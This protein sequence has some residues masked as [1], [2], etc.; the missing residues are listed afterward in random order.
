MELISYVGSFLLAF[1][2]LPELIRTI[3]NKR[4]DI[5]YGMLLSWL[6]GEILVLIYTVSKQ[7]YAL[8]INYSINTL[9]VSIM[10]YYKIKHRDRT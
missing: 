10:C 2:G 3:R 4:C 6:I 5:G 7:E 9:I 1:C 8:V